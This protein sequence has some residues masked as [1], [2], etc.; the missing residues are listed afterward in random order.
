MRVLAN[1]VCAVHL[2]W[3]SGPAPDAVTIANGLAVCEDHLGY[4]QPIPKP[5][6]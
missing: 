2:Q 1:I 5:V 4:A 6:G 3:V